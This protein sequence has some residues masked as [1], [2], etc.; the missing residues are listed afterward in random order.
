MPRGTSRRWAV[1][2]VLVVAATLA[3]AQTTPTAPYDVIIR[4]GTVIDGTG[5]PRFV[6]DVGIVRGHLARIGDLRGQ[7]AATEIAA[8][9][10]VVA[11]GFINIHSHA[12]PEGLVRAEN[13]L[14]QGVTTEIINADGGGATDLDAQLHRLRVAGLAVNV[15]ANIG[16]NAI[17]AAVMG[18]ADR[19]PSPD[20]IERMRGMVV[21]G[22]EQG[23]YGVSAG[24]D[25]KPG[26]YA[27]AEEVGRIVEVARPWRTN[28]TNHDRLTPESGYSSRVGV[29]ETLA[30]GARSGL[31]PVVTHMKA[32]GREQGTAPALLKMMDEA[33]AR[34]TYT[35]ADVYPYL[36][37]QSGLAAL[38]IPG[39]ALDGGREAMLMRFKDPAARARIVKDAEEAMQA[40]FG[41]PQGVYAT[42]HGKE[43]VDAMK[44]FGVASPGEAL[45][46]LLEQSD[47]GAIL[48]FGVESDLV[49]ILTHPTASIACD[50]GAV[51]RPATHPRYWGSYPRVLGRYVREQQ[52]L[53]LEEAVRKM[54]ALP[55]ATIGLVNRGL[56]APGMVADIAVFDPATIIDHA[57]FEMPSAPPVGVRHVLVNGRVALTDGALT[58]ER[59]GA[60][61]LRSPHEPS[62]P[63]SAA[64]ARRV[65]G[66]VQASEVDANISIEQSVG[67]RA[68]RGRLRLFDRTSKT[69]IEMIEPGAL[70]V[71]AG[72][73]AV[74]GRGRIGD[75]ER[76]FTVIVEQ[77][78]PLDGQRSTTITVLGEDG[79][80]LS[81]I[82]PKN[83]LRVSPSR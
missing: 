68:P 54:T 80:Q 44:E 1:V 41:G 23:A 16:F 12:T 22:L 42:G 13:M 21:R 29:A 32:Q 59:A 79:Y 7:K 15:G 48:R 8:D 55:A 60:I 73:A 67:Q 31:V 78:D 76:A 35:A 61:L 18:P 69:S 83:T 34:G 74:T 77:S 3:D 82:V 36:A 10:L 50:C 57:T 33:T 17:W 47:G 49:A 39:W 20:E 2:A 75:N 19:R 43:L 81:R 72:W 40:R 56:L 27:T 24:L 26:Y 51:A 38:L 28:F 58:A 64:L 6:A 14:V 4:N 30:I 70:Q 46:R 65:S 45:L 25:Y 62:R 9:G 5:G 52:A 53:S 37:G 11:P 66:R 63:M 71:A